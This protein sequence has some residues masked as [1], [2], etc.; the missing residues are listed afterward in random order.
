MDQ[1]GVLQAG[2]R[3]F[4]GR[5]GEAWQV[6]TLSTAPTATAYKTEGGAATETDAILAKVDITV[7]HIAGYMQASEEFLADAIGGNGSARSSACAPRPRA[8][9]S[10][11]N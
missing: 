2:P 4:N 7:G 11:R 8:R 6:P 3:I 9:R 10:R 1:S 5:S